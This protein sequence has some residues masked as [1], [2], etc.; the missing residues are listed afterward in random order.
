MAKVA[1]F[2]TEGMLGKS[3]VNIIGQE[4]DVVEF[5]RSGTKNRFSKKSQNF[6]AENTTVAE[7]HQLIQDCDFVFNS[8]AVV[9]QRIPKK[10]PAKVLSNVIRV[11]SNFPTLLEQSLSDQTKIIEIG[12]DCV[13]SGNRGSYIESDLK[14]PTDI[15]GWSKALGEI[16]SEKIMR[17]RTS[18][19]GRQA[20]Q[21]SSL[22]DWF[23]SQEINGK[24]A[25]FTNHFWNGM[26]TLQFSKIVLGIINKNLFSSGTY[27]LYSENKVTKGNLLALFRKYFERTDIEISMEADSVF[28]DRSLGTSFPEM[29]SEI[30]QAAGYSKAP[31]IEEMLEEFAQTTK[32]EG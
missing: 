27:H 25:G 28:I 31:C 12:T 6:D 7:L 11:N 13:F 24:V 10:V 3:L 21:Q 8:I 19:I 18:I 29:N 16:E 2:G 23:L 15:Y 5:N 1:I 20:S 32:M 4:H 26:T 9:K 17:L 14:D 30:W 22:L